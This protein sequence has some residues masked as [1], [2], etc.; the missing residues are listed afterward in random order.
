MAWPDNM[1]LWDKWEQLYIAGQDAK[2][3]YDSNKEMM[4]SGA[5][6]LWPEKESLYELM[7]LRANIGHVAFACEKCNDPRDPTKCEFDELWFDDE[8]YYDS[9]PKNVK[10]ITVG[11]ADPAKGGETKKHDYSA[12]IFLHYCPDHGCCYITADIKRRPV[13]VLI[14]DIARLCK[15]F[16]PVLFGIETNGFQQLI[17]EE[18]VAKYPFLPIAPVE[19]FSIHKNTRI[20]RLALWFQ[21]RFFRF[22]R[23]CKDTKLLMQQILDHPHA[24]H[25]DG[26]DALEGS[27]RV[28]TNV[29]NLS[30]STVEP[31]SDNIGDNIFDN[32]MYM[33]MN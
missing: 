23:H 27:L 21:R 4:D 1:E 5:V 28:L 22:K 17:A 26:T 18:A 24:D 15:V 33:G 19:N 6:V 14:D 10:L 11:Y 3:Y 32:N 13:N 31:Q 8:C 16:D 30:D 29:C 9:L 25:D 12:T 7:V 20:S 2:T